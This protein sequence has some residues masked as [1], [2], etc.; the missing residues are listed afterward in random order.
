MRSRRQTA[1]RLAGE[2]A[3]SAQTPGTSRGAQAPDKGGHSLPQRSLPGAIEL[4]AEAGSAHTV[5][6]PIWAADW[7]IGSGSVES[8]NL[9]V[10]VE[11]RSKG[12][13]M[14]WQRQNVNPMLVLRNVVCNRQWTQTWAAAMTQR[15]ALRTHFRQ[16]ER[17]PRLTR[18]CWTLALLGARLHQ[19]SHPRALASSSTTAAGNSQHATRRPGS[20]YSW[21]QPFLRRPP[22]SPVRPEEVCVKK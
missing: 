6:H 17:K 10:V 21:R 5:P 22:S 7:P 9:G 15:R 20:G 16:A 14:R 12:A 11:A 13:G 2:R 8:G 18:A 1:H 19:M 3:A 4:L